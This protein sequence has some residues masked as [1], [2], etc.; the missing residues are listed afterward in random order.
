VK[1]SPTIP[2]ARLLESTG[3]SCEH[4]IRRLRVHAPHAAS[5]PVGSVEAVDF[6]ERQS[7]AA[8]TITNGVLTLNFVAERGQWQPEGPNG[9]TLSVYAFREENGSLL[10]PGPLVR[11]ATGGEIGRQPR[12]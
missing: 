11:V 6:R 7:K 12:G 2:V 8:G 3:G 4:P 5:S 10:I 1:S 9:R